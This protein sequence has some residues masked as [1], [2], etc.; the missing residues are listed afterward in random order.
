MHTCTACASRAFLYIVCHRE[1][2]LTQ[3][4]PTH[5]NQIEKERRNGWSAGEY[6]QVSQRYIQ[7]GARQPP[8]ARVRGLR[9]TSS[10]ASSTHPPSV[11]VWVSG[12]PHQQAWRCQRT[13]DGGWWDKVVGGCCC[14]CFC[15]P[16]VQAQSR[17]IVLWR[18]KWSDP[19]VTFS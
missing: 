18:P 7:H 19:I 11:S 8:G 15:T 12:P 16:N 9:K 14:L 1:K 5:N 4:F 2:K 17:A 13:A 6:K 3:P 10:P